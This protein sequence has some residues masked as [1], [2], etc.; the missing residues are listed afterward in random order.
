M[1]LFYT[2]IEFIQLPTVRLKGQEAR[3][4]SKVLRLKRGDS[5]HVTDG[6]G[7]VY[8]CV[9]ESVGK[10]QIEA[11]VQ[12]THQEP[13]INPGVSIL[14]GLIKKRD[15]LEFAIEKS[16]E[17]GADQLIVFRGDHS[18]KGN[19]R[20]DRLEAAAISAMKQSLRAYLPTICF[21]KSLKSALESLPDKGLVIH[22]DETLD[23]F[24]P[25]RDS[26]IY[27]A[28]IGPEGGFSEGERGLLKKAG[29]VPYS[30]GSK[31]LRTETAVITMTDR[32]KNGLL[33]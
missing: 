23:G 5:I 29:S 12:S 6:V 7:H 3:H 30:L 26:K 24:Q 28:V 13:K 10:E 15:R 18:E 16:V 33:K 22:A 20:L 8:E 4:A 19:V 14:V 31:R 9:V 17:L 1:N 32:I 25:V 2:P 21:E 27:T 11:I